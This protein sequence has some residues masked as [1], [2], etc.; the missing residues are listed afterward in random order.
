MALLTRLGLI[1][2]VVMLAESGHR[3]FLLLGKQLA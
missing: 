1:F 2:A 3:R